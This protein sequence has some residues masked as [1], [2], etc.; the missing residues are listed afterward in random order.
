MTSHIENSA[1][2][3]NMEEVEE[4]RSLVSDAAL[5]ASGASLVL[6]EL[7]EKICDKFDEKSNTCFEDVQQCLS[8]EGHDNTNLPDVE[9][10]V[11]IQLYDPTS[12]FSVDLERH[13]NKKVCPSSVLF[14]LKKL[15]YSW[16]YINLIL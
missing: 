6:N 12:K 11:E 3:L 8:N 13:Q 5:K 7:N 9:Q 1:T 10:K 4:F 2:S 14:Q 16:S 15:N